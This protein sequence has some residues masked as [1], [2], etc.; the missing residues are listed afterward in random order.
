MRGNCINLLQKRQELSA[1]IGA[2]CHPRVKPRELL[3]SRAL[4]S[5]FVLAVHLHAFTYERGRKPECRMAAERFETGFRV[6]RGVHRNPVEFSRDAILTAP[7]IFHRRPAT[8]RR[9][10]GLIPS[11]SRKMK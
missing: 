4:E 11:W 10:R 6:F 2:I 1:G 3:N 5:D 7:E 9:R 8:L